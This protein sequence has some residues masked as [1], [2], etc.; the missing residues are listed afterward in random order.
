MAIKPYDWMSRG[1]RPSWGICGRL[2][3]ADT[4]GFGYA[5]SVPAAVERAARAAGASFVQSSVGL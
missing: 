3:A 2:A 4:D 5:G 1:P